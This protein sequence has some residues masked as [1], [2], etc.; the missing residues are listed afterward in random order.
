M[1]SNVTLSSA[2][3]LLALIA[4]GLLVTSAVG[5]GMEY[6]DEDEEQNNDDNNNDDNNDDNND[7]RT[8]CSELSE[9][10]C[11]DRAD[12]DPLYE[13][14]PCIMVD[15]AQEEID[16]LPCDDGEHFVGCQDIEDDPRVCMTDADCPQGTM[17]VVY[18]EQ[19]APSAPACVCP[20]CEGPGCECDCDDNDGQREYIPQGECV[21]VEEECYS[22]EDCAPGQACL[23]YFTDGDRDGAPVAPECECACEDGE[24]C[25]PCDCGDEYPR[26]QAGVCVDQDVYCY[27]DR[28]CPE[29]FVCD[30][31]AR[32]E[33]PD[34]CHC[35]QI[36][37]EDGDCEPCDCGISEPA[38]I[39]V[40]APEEV[41]WTDSD[42]AE[43]YYCELDRDTDGFTDCACPDCEDGEDCPPCDCGGARPMPEGVCLPDPTEPHQPTELNDGLA[44]VSCAP[45]DGRAIRLLLSDEPMECAVGPRARIVVELW[46]NFESGSVASV[47][48]GNGGYAEECYQSDDGCS[49]AQYGEF[50][51]QRNEIGD[52]IIGTYFL[53]FGRDN[54]IVG[55]FDFEYCDFFDTDF[56][57]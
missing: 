18:G 16:C 37:D 8:P 52:R 56:C 15:C 54:V 4:V 47:G 53:D 32:R 9:G 33:A 39:C 19:D 36:C 21:P 40:P 5:C 22:D 2:R 20:D 6:V 48:E 27:G 57:G 46:R 55:E 43:G 7:R 24:D 45:D 11:F 29:G 51:I 17:C 41:C 49:V 25:G 50:H 10:A 30:Y 31:D 35:E 26:P 42:C 28:D 14:A 38:G 34:T 44:A 1:T 13:V 23:F 3:R 12:C